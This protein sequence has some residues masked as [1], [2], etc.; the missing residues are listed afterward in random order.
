MFLLL[1]RG[2]STSRW[3]S[4]RTCRTPR[5]RCRHCST[6][7]TFFGT[8]FSCSCIP[9][10]GSACWRTWFFAGWFFWRGRCSR[11]GCGR[12]SIRSRSIPRC[13]VYYW[14]ST[15]S[16][17]WGTS[18]FCRCIPFSFFWSRRQRWWFR[19]GCV[20][21]WARVTILHRAIPPACVIYFYRDWRLSWSARIY[22]S[23]WT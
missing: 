22:W 6:R 23:R 2:R 8:G 14:R 21:I 7:S 9:C 11:R 5:R 17:S 20:T 10:P 12:W 15:S 1:P 4:P 16:T 13:R 3:R 18:F 19:G